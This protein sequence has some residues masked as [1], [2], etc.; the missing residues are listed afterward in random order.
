MTNAVSIYHTADPGWTEALRAFPEALRQP[1]FL[2]GYHHLLECNGDG[3]AELFVYAE[4]ERKFLYPYMVNPIGRIG[5]EVIT[6]ELYDIQSVY[7][8]TGPIA[9][10]PGE[11]FLQ[12]ANEAF[13]AYARE[14]HIVAEFVR[15]NPLLRN[16]ELLPFATRLQVFKDKPFVF[17]PFPGS[18]DALWES[19]VP[20]K[21]RRF[22]R[23]CCAQAESD[24]EVEWGFGTA[25]E[26]FDAFTGLYLRHMD[27]IGADEYYS[28]SPAYFEALF[29]FIQEH[30]TLVWMRYRGQYVA[31]NCYLH[32]GGTVY[33][34][35][36]ARDAGTE[37]PAYLPSAHFM[38]GLLHF[39]AAGF[40]GCLLGGGRTGAEDDSL[41]RFKRAFSTE[42]ADLY[43]GK[44]VH[45]PVQYARL[46]AVWEREFPHLRE[47]RGNLVLRYRFEE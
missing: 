35:H 25:R 46:C 4:G 43:L 27:R 13:E 24:A 47:K 28:H 44:R 18:L 42:T 34:H 37:A 14:R 19:I 2:P 38:H 22:L 16:Q 26:T 9:T 23:N 33:Y 15:F 17:R 11:A 7:G 20:G 29:E 1:G 10:D 31:I 5:T 8:Y 3:R 40:S 39:A 21:K 45:D 36:S 32:E 6:G 30:G 12:R 41:L